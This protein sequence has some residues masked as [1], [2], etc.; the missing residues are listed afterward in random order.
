MHVRA[1]LVQVAHLVHE[2]GRAGR[3]GAKHAERHHSVRTKANDG[4]GW[5]EMAERQQRPR[6]GAELQTVDVETVAIDAMAAARFGRLVENRTPAHAARV[7]V[8]QN[9][10]GA[11]PQRPAR[12]G[13]VLKVRP[14]TEVLQSLKAQLHVST[15]EAAVLH[16]GEEPAEMV[17]GGRHGELHRH[18]GAAEAAQRRKVDPPTMV[19]GSAG[20]ADRQG[21]YLVDAVGRGE[22]AGPAWCPPSD[23][24]V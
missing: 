20:E 14:P 10:R 4:A 12:R 16:S 1:D 15:S 2:D 6:D 8:H 11:R 3:A 7:R 18:G 21:H 13:V 23:R 22:E 17:A 24:A 19:G 5:D 9:R